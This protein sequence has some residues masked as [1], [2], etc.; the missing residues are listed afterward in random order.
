MPRAIVLRTPLELQRE[1][2]ARTAELT[3]ANERLQ[4]EIAARER[5][6]AALRA[7][8]A[9]YRATFENAAVGIA[10]I[11]PDG[12]WLRFNQVCCE[13]TG[14][15]EEELRARTFADITHPDDI[16]ADWALARRL[17]DGKIDR[18]SMEK[19]YLRKD[20][21]PVWVLLTASLLRGEDGDPEQFISVIVDISARIA[22]EEA[23]RHAMAELAMERARLHVSE[24]RLE[25]ALAAGEGGVWD[26]DIARDAATVTAT[27]R[28]LY[29]HS[30]DEPV[31]YEAW[32]ARLHPQDRE[33][34]RRY[35]DDFFRSGTQ[36]RME[37]RIEH[38]VRGERWLGALGRLDRDADGRPLRFLGVNFDIT[39]RKRAEDALLDANQRKDEF[40]ATLSHELRNPLAPISNAL[41]FMR[42]KGLHEP[43]LQNAREII[44]RQVNHMVRL[45]D[46]LLEV[47]RITSGLI[48]LRKEHIG[49]EPAISQAVEGVQP[50]L[51][52][53]GQQLAVEMPPNSVYVHADL[54]RIV[55]V[56]VNLLNNAAKYTPSGGRIALAAWAA[57]EWVSI[58]VS[59]NGIGLTAQQLERIFDLF[60]RAESG[61][62]RAQDGLG[63]GLTLARELVRLHDGELTATSA[64]PGG[65]STF[66][67]RLPVSSQPAAL[68]E[69]RRSEER[70]KD[71]CA[72][73]ILV[74]DDNVDAARSLAMNLELAGHSV[75]SVY[76]GR[77]ALEAYERFEPE[78]VLLDIGMPGMSGYEVARAIRERPRGVDALLVAVTGWGQP[79]DKRR[80]EQAGF[81]LHFTKPVD[82]ARL[83]ALFARERPVRSADTPSMRSPTGNASN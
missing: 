77:E 82:P 38:P 34:V 18:F 21:S 67:V 7:N 60:W 35:A 73:K 6:E 16:E 41:Q 81:D 9:R 1:V 51:Q 71:G 44:E 57:G 47:S 62:P 68:A 53:K 40:L 19:R 42:A 69:E 22:A 74:V 63:I 31:T 54:V 29:G 46:D 78:I 55:Q 64:G 48:E 20:G 27:Y 39:D 52:E 12:R 28:E 70:L 75:Q 17:L 2:Q 32:L 79:E 30:P 8:E 13:I 4:E 36:W 5:S 80:A 3:A 61:R 26:W 50:L 83:I 66:T 11:A 37:Y 72:R 10:H 23:R 33:W 14:Y 43:A 65:G 59:D 49:I 15:S 24:E 58:A 56:L 25:L 76:D 45:V